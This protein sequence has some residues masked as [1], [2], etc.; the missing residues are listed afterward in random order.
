MAM[1][2]LLGLQKNKHDIFLQ[3]SRVSITVVHT[4]LATGVTGPTIFVLKVQRFHGLFTDDFMRS[5][6]CALGSTIIMIDKAFMTNK[7]WDAC[8]EHLIN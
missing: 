7:E 1:S 8:T 2:I 5:K 6:G 4:G 3:E